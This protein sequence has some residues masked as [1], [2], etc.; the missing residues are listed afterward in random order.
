MP[1]PKKIKKDTNTEG[2]MILVE[3]RGEPKKVQT[4]YSDA[5]IEGFRLAEKEPNRLVRI[6][7]IVKQVRGVI[8]AKDVP[9]DFS[10]SNLED[11]EIEF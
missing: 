5:E 9:L 7:K 3:G 1:R 2:Y 4:S 10:L 8:M 11:I 6:L